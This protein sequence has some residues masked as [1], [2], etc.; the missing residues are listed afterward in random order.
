LLTSALATCSAGT[1]KGYSERALATPRKPGSGRAVCRG[2]HA[3]TDCGDRL[4]N[5][6]HDAVPEP[7]RALDPAALRATL[8]HH[9]SRKRVLAPA[10]AAAVVAVVVTGVPLAAHQLAAHQRPSLQGPAVPSPPGGFTASEFLMAAPPQKVVGPATFPRSTCT[11][12]QISA[13]AA[14]RRTGGG[15]LGVIRLVGAVVSHRY[16]VA[17]RCTLPIA[18]GP[19]A[20]IAPDGQHPDG[21]AVARRPDQPARQPAPRHSPQQR[22]RAAP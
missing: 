1:V 2:E 13:T 7:P 18:R 4:A 3:M 5:V 16:G 9:A 19:V 15:V 20:L 10:L 21:A 8:A 22:Q 6:L 17:E 11:S 12:E 14:T